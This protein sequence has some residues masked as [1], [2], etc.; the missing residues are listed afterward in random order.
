MNQFLKIL[1]F[2]YSLTLCFCQSSTWS[3]TQ[4]TDLHREYSNIFLHGN[5]NA[6]SHLW[7]TF[8][9]QNSENLSPETLELMFTGFCAVS[10]SPVR[11]N[12]YNRYLLR[13]PL[14]TGTGS[15]AGAMHYCC[16]PCVCDTQDFIRVDT[17]TVRTSSG[18]KIYHFAVIGN[19]C[20]DEGMLDVPF[21][22]PFDRRETTLRREAREVRCLDGELQGATLSDHGFIIISMFF[23]LPED[24]TMDSEVGSVV[25]QGDLQP[26]RVVQW[27]GSVT[28]QD[29]REYAGWCQQ[30]EANG[31]DSGMGEI[32][33]KVA[34][35]SPVK[36]GGGEEV[37]KVGMGEEEY[38]MR[39][40]DYL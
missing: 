12:D 38:S 4:V 34:G 28:V 5:R 33:R 37:K 17:K 13:L 19:P 26:G 29:E 20:D 6:A 25:L 23:D 2:L 39:T 35:I 9:L 36:V 31:H 3:G 24:N 14:V 10:G 22:Q 8:I 18:E 30:R 15:R 32:F 21:V 16:W 1:G 27:G 7:S 11:P 40:T